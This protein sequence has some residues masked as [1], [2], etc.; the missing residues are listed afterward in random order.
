MLNFKCVALDKSAVCG[1]EVGTH[2]RLH[3]RLLHNG[4]R[5]GGTVLDK[6]GQRGGFW[7]RAEILRGPF[8]LP[9]NEHVEIPILRAAEERKC[10]CVFATHYPLVA[11][12]A[13]IHLDI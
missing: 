9:G 8:S 13:A 3:D 10:A 2:D 11:A 1:P 12:S 4:L 5:L 6:A 7:L